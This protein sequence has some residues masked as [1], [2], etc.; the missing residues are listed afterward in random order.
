MVQLR[1]VGEHEK[2]LYLVMDLVRGEPLNDL[3][4]REGALSEDRAVDIRL[5]V[6]A[7]LEAAHAAGIVHRDLKP[8]NLIV[9]K[10]GDREHVRILDFGLSKLSAIDGMQSAHRSVTGAIIGTLAYM[11]PEQLSGEKEIDARSDVFAAGL[12]LHEMLA[13]HHPYPGDSG[14]VVA[15]KLLREPVP[16]LDP[17][18]VAKLSPSTLAALR[19]SLER[20]RDARFSSAFAFA[21]ALE[22]RGP[23]SDTSRVTT[24]QDAREALA[25]AEA[26]GGE[27]QT[28]EVEEGAPD[29]RARGRAGRRGCLPRDARGRRARDERRR[30]GG[31]GRPTSR[32]RPQRT[33]DP[34][35]TA[36]TVI[37]EE[38]GTSGTGVAETPRS[39]DRSDAARDRPSRRTPASRPPPP[40]ET[41]EQPAVTP[42]APDGARHA[43]AARRGARDSPS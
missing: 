32:H 19:Q 34:T 8:S 37:P 25:R 28:Q 5:Q 9:E 18:R 24:I 6:L 33:P 2:R 26:A 31:A 7:G 4:R 16:D 39:A 30:R 27:G 42:E 22:G 10:Q 40:V 41:P 38:P 1:H 23:P 14:I 20:D 3:L 15:A 13:G 11:S 36:G 35:A 43:R 12:V 17:K 29:R 21:Q